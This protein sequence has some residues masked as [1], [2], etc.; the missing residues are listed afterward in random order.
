LIEK[1]GANIVEEITPKYNEIV[2]KFQ[3]MYHDGSL[4]DYT[5]N[6]DNQ[7]LFELH[8]G[9]YVDMRVHETYYPSMQ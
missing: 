5:T 7:Q 2:E 8:D 6:P 1:F 3:S 4:I 9:I